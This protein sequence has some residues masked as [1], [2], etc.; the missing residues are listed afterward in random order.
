MDEAVRAALSRGHRIDITTTG[1]KSGQPR[2]IEIVFANIDGTIV[3]SGLPGRRSWYANLIAHPEFTFHLKGRVT[4]D[5]P[6][7]A[8]PITDPER[9]RTIFSRLLQQLDRPT[10]LE[11]WVARSPLVEVTFLENGEDGG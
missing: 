10:S 9:R 4:A 3:I 11:D 7:R 6:A 1:R 5:L 2:R 8:T